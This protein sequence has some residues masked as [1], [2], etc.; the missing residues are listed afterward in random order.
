M[1][2]LIQR[3][4]TIQSYLDVTNAQ[5]I[6]ERGFDVTF[7]GL[8]FRALNVARCNSMTFTASLKPHHDGCLGYFWNGKVWKFSL[9]GIPGKEHHDLS[10]IAVKY[11]GGGHKSACGFAIKAGDLPEIFGGDRVR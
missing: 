4:K 6:T 8:T 9:Y 2:K 11:G 1:D 7:E 5:I 10:K 3:G